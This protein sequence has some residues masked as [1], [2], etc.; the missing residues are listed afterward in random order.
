[1]LA[2]GLYPNETVFGICEKNK[3]KFI[4]SLQDKSLKTIQEELYLPRIE[5]PMLEIF[6]RQPM[7]E[8]N[9][10]FRFANGMEYHKK[11]KL[12]W[13]QCIEIK[14]NTNSK[15]E[16]VF[17]KKLENR[18]EHVT[19]IEITKDNVSAVSLGGR[20][21][22]KIENQGFN[23]EKNGGYE[24]EHKYCRNSYVGLQNY[25]TLLLIAHAI[26]QMMEKSKT[27]EA[28]LKERQRKQFIIFG[29]T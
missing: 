1:M 25:Y 19:N 12:N 28:I 27:I 8:I 15:N 14:E 11:Y 21:R 17:G 22:W 18:F 10:K 20:L 13:L 9:R 6:N 23:T 3:W 16:N 2:D 7:W 4:I 5:K 26:N 29:F 24:L